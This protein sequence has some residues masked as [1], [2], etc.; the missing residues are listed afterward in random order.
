[1]TVS[2]YFVSFLILYNSLFGAFLFQKDSVNTYVQEEEVYLSFRYQ[3]VIDEI[4]VAY[5]AQ[6]QFF[7]PLTELFDLFAINYELSPAS[8][9]ISGFFIKE[10]TK[11]IMDFNRRFAMVNDEV[12]SISANER[13]ILY[14]LLMEIVRR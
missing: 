4:V 1:V 14:S 10:N 6:D 8:L 5:Y 13:E 7:L 3:G 11:Y 2:R 12:F 9:S